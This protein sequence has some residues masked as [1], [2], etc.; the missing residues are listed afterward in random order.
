MYLEKRPDNRV[1]T[2]SSRP[3]TIIRSLFKASSVPILSKPRQNIIKHGC[4]EQ[5]K[6]Q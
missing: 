1:G 3:Y 4:N 2:D 5:Y 6:E